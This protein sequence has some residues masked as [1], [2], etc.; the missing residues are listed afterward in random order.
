MKSQ[1]IRSVKLLLQAGAFLNQ[2]TIDEMEKISKYSQ[3]YTHSLYMNFREIFID[4]GFELDIFKKIH[5]AE[6]VEVA[7]TTIHGAQQMVLVFKLDKAVKALYLQEFI[8]S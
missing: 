4:A 2:K 8:H 6:P 1:S 3:D 5:L 7:L